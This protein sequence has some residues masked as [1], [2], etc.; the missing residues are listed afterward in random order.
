MVGDEDSEYVKLQLFN[1]AIDRQ[2]WSFMSAVHAVTLKTFRAC[3]PTRC[4]MVGLLSMF[5][6][7][8][9]V[10]SYVSFNSK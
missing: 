8:F 5:S 2:H 3:V 6:S 9:V 4:N 1:A 7:S 10:L